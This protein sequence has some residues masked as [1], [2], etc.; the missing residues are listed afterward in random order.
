MSTEENNWYIFRIVPYGEKKVADILD[1]A[2]IEYY[3]PFQT[4][5]R[6]W[7]TI[8]KEMQVPVFSGVGFACVDSFDF[9][10]L[11]M[12][13]EISLLKD[14]VGGYK[15]IPVSQIES[16]KTNPAEITNIL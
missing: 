10:M 16:L 9:G 1:I 14:S 7:N 2:G 5:K 13:Q 3:I 8:E 6:R 15:T 12:I 4:V 11:E